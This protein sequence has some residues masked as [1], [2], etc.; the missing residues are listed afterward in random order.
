MPP[1]QMEKLYEVCASP[2]ELKT[3]VRL[4]NAHHMN[5]CF[6]CAEIYWPA[7]KTFILGE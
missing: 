1:E 6:T 5:G 7:L 2:N 3:L 4:P